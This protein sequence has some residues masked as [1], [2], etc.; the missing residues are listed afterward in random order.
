L[1]EDEGEREEEEEERI[2]LRTYLSGVSLNMMK[3]L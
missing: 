3:G 2:E 1:L